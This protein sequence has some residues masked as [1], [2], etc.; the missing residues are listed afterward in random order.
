MKYVSFCIKGQRILRKKGDLCRF[1]YALPKK[2]CVFSEKQVDKSI[3][4]LYTDCNKNV[5][6]KMKWY[7]GT[8][9]GLF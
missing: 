6:I 8:E 9:D 7:G 5:T 2:I 4:V 3:A 1:P